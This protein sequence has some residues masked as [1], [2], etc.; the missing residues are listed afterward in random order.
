MLTNHLVS[1]ARPW[2]SGCSRRLLVLVLKSILTTLSRGGIVFDFQATSVHR[3]GDHPRTK[4]APSNFI[5]HFAIFPE[6][7]PSWY[8][9]FE[10][11]LSVAI[12]KSHIPEITTPQ[13][14]IFLSLACSAWK[15]ESC[16][17]DTWNIS[18]W[19]SMK[20]SWVWYEI[21]LIRPWNPRETK[22]THIHD[23]IGRLPF[24]IMSCI[25]YSSG[26]RIM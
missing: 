7:P 3:I 20:V 6:L 4:R 23:C 18:D 8:G 24:W 25:S 17:T 9:Q 15:K 13:S 16:P 12:P 19:T 10:C 1:L 11:A 21:L 14:N 2:R 5:G 26:N 22:V